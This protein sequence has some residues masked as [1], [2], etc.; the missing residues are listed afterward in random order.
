MSRADWE[1]PDLFGRGILLPRE[2]F[3]PVSVTA[4]ASVPGKKS[5][6]RRPARIHREHS[7]GDATQI[8]SELLSFFPSL[9]MPKTFCFDFLFSFYYED[10]EI[11]HRGVLTKH[12]LS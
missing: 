6:A 7:R 12:V 5:S 3:P 1:S 4:T 10:E 11:D 9:C 2:M 8:A